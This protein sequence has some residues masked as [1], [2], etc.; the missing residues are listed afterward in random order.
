MILVFTG[1]SME[2]ARPRPRSIETSVFQIR[3]GSAQQRGLAPLWPKWQTVAAGEP[4]CFETR[5]RGA[6]PKF[7]YIMLEATPRLLKAALPSLALTCNWLPLS[8]IKRGCWV[9]IG[10]SKSSVLNRSVGPQMP[11]RTSR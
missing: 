7:L 8:G 1:G 5:R 4:C 2:P 10:P 6:D 3:S 9:R 11:S